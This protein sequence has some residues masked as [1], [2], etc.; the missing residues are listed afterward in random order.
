[1]ATF[2]VGDKVRLHIPSPGLRGH[3]HHGKETVILA[4]PLQPPA[5]GTYYITE[6]NRATGSEGTIES[7]LR[8]LTNPD[9][10][11][12]KAA[13]AF[14]GRLKKL[15]KEPIPLTPAQLDEVRG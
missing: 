5:F 2:K 7:A 1:M 4:G 12:D 13:D 3:Q 9:A 15:A 14:I 6:L 8:P 10:E 11:S